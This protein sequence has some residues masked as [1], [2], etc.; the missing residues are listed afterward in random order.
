MIIALTLVVIDVDHFEVA[1]EFLDDD[2]HF[3]GE[4][5]V[6]G[7]EAGA[8]LATFDFT[9]EVH[10]VADVAEEEVGE[11]V[12]EEE[13]D[14]QFA[15]AGGDAVEGVGSVV[16]VLEEIGLRGAAFTFG[17]GVEDDVDAAE[18]GSGV[19]GA[20]EFGDGGLADGGVEGGDVDAVGEG[21][22]EGDGVDLKFMQS[23]AG[24][25]D[26][27]DVVV[28]EV[29]REGADF[30]LV[31]AGGVDGIQDGQDGAAVEAPGGEG[32]GPFEGVHGGGRVSRLKCELAREQEP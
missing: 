2:A 25:F 9:E 14:A 12:F 28:V 8:D 21:S 5:G 1:G 29:G 24:A 10:H 23:L 13:V 31:E 6:A 32:Y 30:D 27:G 7:V 19:A 11:H 26:G 3:A 22:V 20:D 15:A 17:S 18:Q 4:V 16:H